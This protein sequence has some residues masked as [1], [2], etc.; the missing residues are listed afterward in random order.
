MHGQHSVLLGKI[1]HTHLHF[2]FIIHLI[3]E[4]HIKCKLNRALSESFAYVHIYIVFFKC[5][6]FY[7]GT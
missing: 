2:V 7:Y 5:T 3:F 1:S 4:L 6:Y